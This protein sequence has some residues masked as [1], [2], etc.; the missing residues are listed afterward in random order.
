MV[1]Q[2]FCEIWVGLAV[3]VARGS[4]LLIRVYTVL[5]LVLVG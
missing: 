5:H 2:N 4:N 1:A 3:W